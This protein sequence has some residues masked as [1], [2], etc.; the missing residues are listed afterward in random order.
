MAAVH[1]FRGSGA[2]YVTRA[3]SLRFDSMFPGGH[4]YYP[5]VL[6]IWYWKVS[7]LMPDCKLRFVVVSAIDFC[8]EATSNSCTAGHRR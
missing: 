8:I 6:Q 7:L 3:F 1:E 4:R 5:T 2:E